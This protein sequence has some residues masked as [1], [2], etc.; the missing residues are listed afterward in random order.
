MS[1]SIG[2]TQ[3]RSVDGSG[4]GGTGFCAKKDPATNKQIT[5]NLRM[6][7][8]YRREKSVSNQ[9]RQGSGN[10]KFPFPPEPPLYF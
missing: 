1:L 4:V 10:D 5:A 8:L 9:E 6:R 2:Q 7:L 3:T